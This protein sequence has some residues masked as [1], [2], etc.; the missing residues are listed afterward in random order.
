M[1]LS[2][3]SNIVRRVLL[4]TFSHRTLAFIRWDLH[5]LWIRFA[6][7]VLLRKR[8]LL[9]KIAAAEPPIYLNLGSGPRGLAD[10]HWINVD[11][12]SDTNVHYLMDFTRSWPFGD[13]S[14][15]GI[16]CEHVFEH[17]DF[18]QGQALL[19]ESLR[20]LQPGGCIRIIVPDGKRIL[21]TYVGNP[22]ELLAHRDHETRCAME[23]V[24]SYFRQRYEHQCIYDR[25][26]L[27]Y[28]LVRAGFDQIDKV[29]FGEGAAS[30]SV[31][32]DDP[33]YEWESLYVE[34]IKP[35]GL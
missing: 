13:S 7:F 12:Y 29:S 5:F 4:F 19:R 10:N 23:V 1:N 24:N 34:A 9:K 14:I 26:L 32:L 31:L 33:R 27:E 2:E 8:E 11:G 3:N 18:E 28:Q 6:N 22:T 21:E 15:D 35:I 20:V 16:F 25:Q 30:R 17:F